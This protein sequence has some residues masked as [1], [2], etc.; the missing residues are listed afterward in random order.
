MDFWKK[1]SVK[2]VEK[3]PP[4]QSTRLFKLPLNSLFNDQ[5]VDLTFDTVMKHLDKKKRVQH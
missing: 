3:T 5:G 4:K 1:I 2:S